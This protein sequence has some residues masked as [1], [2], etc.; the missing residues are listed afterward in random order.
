MKVKEIKRVLREFSD[1]IVHFDSLESDGVRA[2]EL[3]A[4]A[5]KNK[6]HITANCIEVLLSKKRILITR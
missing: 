4:S 6:K 1:Y 5:K 3:L 2:S